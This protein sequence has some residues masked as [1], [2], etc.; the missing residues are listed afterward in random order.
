MTYETAVIWARELGIKVRK[1]DQAWECWADRVHRAG[2]TGRQEHID[3]A[4]NR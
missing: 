1:Q 4:N 3:E 2:I